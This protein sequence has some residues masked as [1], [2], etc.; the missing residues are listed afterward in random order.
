LVIA[1]GLVAIV[2]ATVA[3]SRL[4]QQADLPAAGVKTKGPAAF[5]QLENV[6]PGEAPVSLAAFR[7]TP[8]VLNFWASWCVPCRREMPFFAAVSEQHKGRVAF[9]GVNHQDQRPPALDL[10]AETGV[11]YPSGFD[12]RGAVAAAYGLFGMPTTVFISTQG[13]VLERRTGEMSRRELEETIRRLF[14]T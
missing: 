9:V 4:V 14:R 6:R 7:G 10:L 8:V 5:F 12:P 1:A 3:A 13:E 2:A 11:P